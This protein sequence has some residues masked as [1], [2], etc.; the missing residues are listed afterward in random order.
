MQLT[1][2]P[3]GRSR[4]VSPMVIYPP[5]KVLAAST[6]QR[7]RQ[8]T[9]G[10]AQLLTCSPYKTKLVNVAEEK[11]KVMTERNDM[12]KA[13]EDNK[14][15]MARQNQEEVKR[16]NTDMLREKSKKA[17]ARKPFTLRNCKCGKKG[18]QN[19]HD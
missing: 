16:K 13:R 10:A 2:S 15:K 5:P 18:Q 11:A 9:H 7:K 12:K 4:Y 14:I 17:T 6:P 19:V 3:P 1:V 8:S